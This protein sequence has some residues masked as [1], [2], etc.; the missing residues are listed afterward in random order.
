VQWAVKNGLR[1]R[2]TPLFADC[3]ACRPRRKARAVVVAIASAFAASAFAASA[4]V[5]CAIAAPEFAASAFAGPVG[6]AGSAHQDRKDRPSCTAW[7]ARNKPCSFDWLCL[8][9]LGS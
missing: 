4:L 9:S 6:P 1:V 7:A 2:V 3:W 5:V 8:E